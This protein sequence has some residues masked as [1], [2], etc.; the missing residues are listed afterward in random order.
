[1][2]FKPIAIEII[3]KLTCYEKAHFRY[4]LIFFL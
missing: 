2:G 4:R 1:M 3:F